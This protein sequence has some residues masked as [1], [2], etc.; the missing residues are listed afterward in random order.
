MQRALRLGLASLL[1][2]TSWPCA[3]AQ[4]PPRS[5][6]PGRTANPLPCVKRQGLLCLPHGT[7]PVARA[8]PLFEP[9]DEPQPTEDLAQ[10]I[11]MAYRSSPT[12]EMQR[13][14]LRADDEDFALA[15]SELRPYSALQIASVFSRTVDGRLSQASGFL[16]TDT[17]TSKT[18]S[19]SASVNQPLYT[20]GKAAADRAAALA[21]IRAGRA[22]LRG[23]E[24]DVL[25]QVITTYANIRLDAE[26]LRLRAANLKQLD[27]TLDEVKA[28]Q[29]A[30]ELTRTDIGLADQQRQYAQALYNVAQQ[31]WQ[32]DR[33]I[34][35]ALIGHEPG[36]LAPMP[37]LA[38]LPETLD[39]VLALSDSLNPELAAAIANEQQARAAITA[40][41]AQGRP[42]LMLSGSAT[43]NGQSLPF[44]LHNQDQVFAG[45]A[46]LT[47]PLTNGGRVGAAVARAED[48][49]A[50]AHVGIES[51]RRQVI[52][53]IVGAWT[54]IKATQ[55]NI[56]VNQ[57]QV[58]AARTYDQG[59]FEEYRAGLR[60][61]FDVL[62]AHG[63]VRDAQIA[64]AT[65]RHD[66]YVAQA[67]LLR[68]IGL[69]EARAILTH[70]ALY[71]PDVNLTHAAARSA[72]PLDA[73]LRAVD[74]LAPPSSR[75]LSLQPLPPDLKAP[76]MV[77]AETPQRGRP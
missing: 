39:D 8:I 63:I 13:Y 24:G 27:F 55:R 10:A 59:T 11:D 32:Q 35:A 22:Q 62:Y 77:P 33:A 2:G 18:L 19:A 29:I 61:T 36:Q 54:Q 3:L 16:P 1:A 69:L 56:D 51:A 67:T 28:R 46:M 47:I 38:H 58:A 48:Q 6:L 52:A 14:K 53:D 64:L 66:L 42:T 75:P 15:L 71:D 37:Q 50:A 76:A 45:Q 17:T 7:V 74:A 20:G 9:E 23:T 30:G 26:I 60:S 43:L 68:K 21:E 70:S 49:E 25:L 31:Q 44:Y 4:P 5:D 65:V 73:A 40:A 41:R 12:I 57:L 34:Y 72:L